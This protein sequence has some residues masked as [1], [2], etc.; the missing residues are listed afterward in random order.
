MT[1]LAFDEIHVYAGVAER[2][3][4]RVERK[5]VHR[6]AACCGS[7]SDL[8]RKARLTGDGYFYLPAD[9]WPAD[10]ESVDVLKRWVVL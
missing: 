8:A 9:T 1:K 4:V 3:G 5:A 10:M 7:L 2:T 6:S